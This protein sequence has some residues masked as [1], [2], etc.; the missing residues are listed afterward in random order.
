MNPLAIDPLFSITGPKPSV[1]ESSQ[2]ESA[3]SDRFRAYLS[4]AEDVAQPKPPAKKSETETAPIQA[5]EPLDPQTGQQETFTDEQEQTS[6]PAETSESTSE[7][8]ESSQPEEEPTDEIVLSAVATAAQP[9]NENIETSVDPEHEVYTEG[10]TETFSAGS[11]QPSSGQSSSPV[12]ETTGDS[13]DSEKS[14]AKAEAETSPLQTALSA[15][16][17]STVAPAGQDEAKRS[18]TSA[19][20]TSASVRQPLAKQ[21]A[22]EE[23]LETLPQDNTAESSRQTA[24]NKLD[25][26]SGGATNHLAAT[27]AELALP[28]LNTTTEATVDSS[29]SSTLATNSETMAATGR[30]LGDLL[31]GKVASAAGTTA[32]SSREETPTVDRARFVQR[33][34]GAIRSAQQ[35]DGQIQLRLSP[36]ELGTLRINIVMKE[37]VLTAHLE[38]ET[39]AART[40][41][42]DNLPTLRQR[43]AE[44][45]I[46]IEKF[47]VDVGREGHQQTDNREADDRQTNHSRSQEHRPS[48]THDQAPS[49]TTTET[50]GMQPVTASGLDVRI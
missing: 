40:V 39:A 19:P 43:L 10:V 31:S 33:V 13:T 3:T 24:T 45:E 21:P 12:A 36:P 16:T 27:E 44:Q 42:L 41:L 34:G 18:Q 1:R 8:A 2:P 25:V 46:R 20:T 6:T 38:T 49:F 37:G 30:T 11:Q 35:R 29:T 22:T 9:V 48:S 15:V 28:N 7:T 50:K 5:D 4:R 23:A 26:P 47:D 14:S 17:Q 32:E